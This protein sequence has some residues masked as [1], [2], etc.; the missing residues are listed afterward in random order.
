LWP[1]VTWCVA[2][3][4]Y[5]YIGRSFSIAITSA[6]TTGYEPFNACHSYIRVLFIKRKGLL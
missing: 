5:M 4:P 1:V 2:C 6:Y 3:S